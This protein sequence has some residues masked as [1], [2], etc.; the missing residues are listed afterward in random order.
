MF[1]K[2]SKSTRLY[3]CTPFNPSAVNTLVIHMAGTL[4]T[5]H[6]LKPF[7]LKMNNNVKTVTTQTQEYRDGA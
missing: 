7:S 5:L 6:K 3:C 1:S 2:W 4:H